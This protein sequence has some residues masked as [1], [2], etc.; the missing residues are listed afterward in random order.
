MLRDE[1]AKPLTR[2]VRRHRSPPKKRGEALRLTAELTAT[3]V[4]PAVFVLDNLFTR[5]YYIARLLGRHETREP[6]N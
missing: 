4:R 6:P 1:N 3:L 5:L 2:F